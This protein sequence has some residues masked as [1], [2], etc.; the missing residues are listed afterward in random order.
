MSLPWAGLNDPV[1]PATDH[2][3]RAAETVRPVRIGTV[4]QAGVGVGTGVGVGV[5]VG[6]GVGVGVGG[7]VG[8]G[9]GV[10]V[11]DGIVLGKPVDVGGVG[12]GVGV[13]PGAV[14]S[15][16]RAVVWG[17]RPCRWALPSETSSAPAIRRWHPRCPPMATR[18]ASARC[19]RWRRPSEYRSLPRHRPPVETHPRR[20][21][22]GRSP[23]RR[24]PPRRSTVAG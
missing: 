18:P 5:G 22:R 10:G 15:P 8:V 11:G 20:S 13:G 17:A 24:G 23:R 21:T 19:H 1:K 12:L 4:R 3:V 7:R 2:A 9:V 16:G 6:I 14:V